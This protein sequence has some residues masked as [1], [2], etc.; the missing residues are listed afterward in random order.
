MAKKFKVKLPKRIAGV[1]IP[2]AVRKGPV[3]KFLNSSAGQLILAEVL[4]IAGR[5]LA[6]KET[7]PSSPAGEGV[8]HPI[9]TLK[10]AARGGAA[11]LSDPQAHFE[12]ASGRLTF[13]L[14][15]GIRAFRAALDGSSDS[16]TDAPRARGET[17]AVENRDAGKKKQTASPSDQTPH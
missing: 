9:D 8:R 15:E 3:A 5:S 11:R 16:A 10:Q 12:R 2:K 17:S 7:D 13:A 14:N 6:V 1:K 4:L